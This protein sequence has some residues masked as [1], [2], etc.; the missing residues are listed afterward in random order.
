ML[1]LTFG[2]KSSCLACTW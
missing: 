1:I 2:K